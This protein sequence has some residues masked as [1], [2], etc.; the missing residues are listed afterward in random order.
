M[1]IKPQPAH[2]HRSTLSQS[3]K[4]FKA[5]HA[6]KGSLKQIAKGNRSS[7]KSNSSSS[8]FILTDA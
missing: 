3:N 6:T 8:L 4:S 2:H 7:L 1:A 5:R